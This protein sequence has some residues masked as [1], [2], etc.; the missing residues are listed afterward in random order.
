MQN[1]SVVL[2]YDLLQ[3]KKYSNLSSLVDFY[4]MYCQ[5]HVKK[6]YSSNNDNDQRI[7]IVSSLHDYLTY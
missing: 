6:Y 1:G 7:E 3:N 2:K 4:E 5:I